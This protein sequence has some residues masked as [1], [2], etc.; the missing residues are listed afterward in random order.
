MSRPPA[1]ISGA[2]GASGAASGP[3]ANARATARAWGAGA[4][5]LAAASPPAGR[6]RSAH[7]V[8]RPCVQRPASRT[9]SSARSVGNDA[10]TSGG[11]GIT[12]SAVAHVI[13]RAGGGMAWPRRMVPASC[14]RAS[15]HGGME[16]AGAERCDQGRASTCRRAAL[17]PS[18]LRWPTVP[19]FAGMLPRCPCPAS[20]SRQTRQTGRQRPSF[21]RPAGALQWSMERSRSLD[22]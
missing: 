20:C 8:T 22:A 2:T 6:S 16:R 11:Q 9:L 21:R 17:S 12:A 10:P 14:Q 19:T 13:W 5:L 15:V 1:A 4:C 18:R 7:R 3:R